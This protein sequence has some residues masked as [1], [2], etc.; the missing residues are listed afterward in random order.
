MSTER[1]TRHT[2]F[3]GERV[4]LSVKKTLVGWYLE[5]KASH[6][7]KLTDFA[8]IRGIRPSTFSDW[9]Q[10]EIML[11]EIGV[12]NFQRV[13]KPQYAH[14]KA[15]IDHFV[16]V[17]REKGELTEKDFD[18]KQIYRVPDNR[19]KPKDERVLYQQ[20]AVLTNKEET[21]SKFKIYKGKK[22]MA[23]EDK[24]AKAIARGKRKLQ[25]DQAQ[26]ETKKT[27][28]AKKPRTSKAKAPI[29]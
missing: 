9:V 2:T 25:T 23:A 3:E 10:K 15:N 21:I 22:Q 18:D 4:P 14:M 13:S 1:I 17:F 24:A 11:R 26:K 8:K 20:R 5:D 29:I 7:A 6:N 16:A 19:T 27:P 28:K 12:N